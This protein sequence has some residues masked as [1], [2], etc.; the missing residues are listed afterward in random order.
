MSMRICFI[1]LGTMGRPMAHNLIAG[2][3]TLTV[4]DAVPDAASE[5]LA[6]G[7]AWAASARDVGAASELTFTALPGPAEV[8]AAVLGSDGLLEG[9][10]PSSIYVDMSTSI[11]ATIQ[12]I[13]ELAKQRNIG[14]LDGPVSG[15]VRGARKATLVF[16]VGGDH[17]VFLKCEPVLHCM[18]EAVFHMGDLGTGY[19]A[20]LVN[21]YMGM[22][23]AVAAMEAMT[24]G[25]KAG[26]NPAALLDVVNAG[27]G[28]SHMS[29]TLFP[30]LIFPRTFEPTRFSMELGAKDLRLAVTLAQEL[31]VPVKVGDTVAD[32]L[33]DAVAQGLGAK[34]FSTY[35]TLLEGAAGV[36]VEA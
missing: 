11:P 32:A 26:V 8:E 33:K 35:I 15:G 9:M 34:D 10:T 6:E 23:N 2:G 30:Y 25:T 7:A 36:V 4:H 21:N 27:T 31:G 14:V 19:I 29:K 18:G 20:K 22:S 12:R 24:L 28:M 17:D 16:M 3:H 1:G 13:A 5:L